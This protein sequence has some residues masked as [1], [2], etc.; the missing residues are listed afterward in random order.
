MV[1]DLVVNMRKFYLLYVII[2]ITPVL[3]IPPSV[4]YLNMH[5]NVSLEESLTWGIPI[6]LAISVLLSLF[7]RDLIRPQV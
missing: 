4:Y 6:G 7:Y 2:V 5:Q 1:L 3:I